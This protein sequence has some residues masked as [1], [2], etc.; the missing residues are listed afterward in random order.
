MLELHLEPCSRDE[1]DLLTERLEAMG[2]V[3][4]SLM[5]QEDNPIL[6]PGPGETP[7]WDRLILKA[8]Y[9]HEEEAN[10]A[11]SAL[12]ID[13]PLISQT[14]STLPDL[15]W[16]R[17]CLEQFVPQQFGQRLWVC[18]S[19]LTPPEPDHI[20]LI[21]DPGL[22]FGTGTHPTTSLC[23]TWLS[24][25]T[26]DGEDILDYGCGSGILALAALKLGA[27]HAYAVDIDDQALLAIQHNAEANH[28]PTG[29]LTI[30]KPHQLTEPVDTLLANILLSPLLTLQ[31]TFHQYLRPQGRLI[32]SG[33]FASQAQ[34]LIDAYH[35]DFV[36]EETLL[37]EEWALIRFTPRNNP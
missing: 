19:W 30:G 27:H 15:E 17:V 24:Q 6:E 5:D 10:Q 1:V 8:I 4:I 35:A 26:L 25:T 20:N 16:E 18:P 33:I 29:R 34:T 22:A 13:Y 2:A 36:H 12:A 11:Q 23:L 31:Q 7:L 9:L 32:V 21:L 3:S 14:L 37:Q 28:I